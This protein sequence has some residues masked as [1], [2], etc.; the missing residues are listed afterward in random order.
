M[1]VFQCCATA[2]YYTRASSP[3][4]QQANLQAWITVRHASLRI[5]SE[6]SSRKLS[7]RISS[8]S[9]ATVLAASRGVPKLCE[10]ILELIFPGCRAEAMRQRSAYRNRAKRGTR[11]VGTRRFPGFSLTFCSALR[12]TWCPSKLA[13]HAHGLNLSWP[14]TR[15]DGQPLQT[16][17]PSPSSLSPP[18]LR[19]YHRLTASCAW[20]DT[21]L[22]APKHPPRHHGSELLYRQF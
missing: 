8:A 9:Q 15:G 5:S 16:F 21:S 2:M 14:R 7:E 6:S 1:F 10:V 11:R 13:L 19:F 12:I 22:P 20:S 17:P 3:H 4:D 18:N